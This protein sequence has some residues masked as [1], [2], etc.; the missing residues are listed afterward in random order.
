[1]MLCCLAF[2]LAPGAH[3]AAPLLTVTAS[4]TAGQAPLTV[5]L[6]ASGDAASYSWDLGDGSSAAGSTVEHTYPTGLWTATATATAPDGATSQA[7]VQVRA[8]SVSLAAPT[9]VTYQ[10]GVGGRAIGDRAAPRR[11]GEDFRRPDGRRGDTRHHEAGQGRRHRASARS[12]GLGSGFEDRIS[13][14]RVSAARRRRAR[15]R[16]RGAP[17][18]A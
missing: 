18:P 3:A 15:R 12:P 14:D 11:P 2:V 16:D 8:E 6:S 7:Q 17:Q 10:A 4:A 9:L 13:H 5:T 1:M